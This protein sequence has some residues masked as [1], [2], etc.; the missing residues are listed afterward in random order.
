MATSAQPLFVDDVSTLKE[1][2]RLGNIVDEDAA[3][4]IIN[5]AILWSRSKL[6]R[7]LG[8]EYI[9]QI[10]ATA[11]TAS[12]LTQGE[13]TR[14]DANSLEVLMVKR[15]LLIH[16]PWASM[17]SAGSMPGFY[18][19]EAP[20]RLSS[21]LDRERLLATIEQEAN[22]LLQGI[23]GDL[24]KTESCGSVTQ[25]AV[26]ASRLTHADGST[27]PDVGAFPGQLDPGNRDSAAGVHGSYYVS[28]SYHRD[29]FS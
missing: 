9:P 7:A 3:G 19:K 8:E 24:S 4:P 20:F 12:P 16:L 14:T 13:I 11:F 21:S 23:C 6:V 5:E 25:R 26:K 15:Y 22:G 17:D 29:Q 1:A 2:L 10:L 18:N 28:P 27:P